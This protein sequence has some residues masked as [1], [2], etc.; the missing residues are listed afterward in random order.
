MSKN[1]IDSEIR[2][3]VESFVDDLTD[4]IRAA[5][6]EAV[7]VAIAGEQ[8]APRRRAAK[9]SGRKAAPRKAKRG[10]RIRRT[11]AQVEQLG[12][13]VIA[14][15]KK[16]PGQR[17]GEIAK[18]LGV[19][20]KDAR[21]PAFALLEAGQLKTTGQRGGTRYFPKGAKAAAAKTSRK[22]KVTKRKVTK[23]RA[24]KRKTAKRAAKK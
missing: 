3:R 6:I 19:A 15:V 12:A 18:A 4:L 11:A 14:H 13:R 9:R 5:A 22:K 16:S 7:Q 1:S 21:R 17:L 20:T 8:A 10:K 24:A 23:R 2:A